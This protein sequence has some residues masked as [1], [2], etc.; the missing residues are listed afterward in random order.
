MIKMS[1]YS[2]FKQQNLLLNQGF[3]YVYQYR[4]DTGKEKRI[5]CIDYAKLKDK[6]LK[7]GLPFNE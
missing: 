5:S 2:I 3:T 7:K 4:D 6:V 1:N